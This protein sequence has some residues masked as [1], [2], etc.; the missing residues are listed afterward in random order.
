MPF[1]DRGLTQIM[2]NPDLADLRVADARDRIAPLLETLVDRAKAQGAVRA[3][4]DQTDLIF[5]QVAL[6]AIIDATRAIAPDLY[7]RSWPS[8]STA[9][10]P[11][12]TSSPRCPHRP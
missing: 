6:A 12:G 2:N 11:T 9:S 7:R 10:E 4:L 8:S 5:T 3:D 1:G